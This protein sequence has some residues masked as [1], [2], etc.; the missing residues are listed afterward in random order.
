MR[1]VVK[2]EKVVLDVI[3]QRAIHN[4]RIVYGAQLGAVINMLNWNSLEGGTIRERDE[5]IASGEAPDAKLYNLRIIVEAEEITAD[6]S[7]SGGQ[8][9]P[10]TDGGGAGRT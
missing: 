10:V 9:A 5:Y 6:Q 4:G 8:A 1:G 7:S 3:E 2:T